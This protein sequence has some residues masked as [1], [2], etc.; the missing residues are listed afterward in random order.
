MNNNRTFL[1]ELTVFWGIVFGFLLGVIVW[2]F[3]VP[4]DTE[5]TKERAK[6]QH[7]PP[8]DTNSSS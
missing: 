5:S 3:R 8:N 6:I 2:L 1:D 4:Q 7:V